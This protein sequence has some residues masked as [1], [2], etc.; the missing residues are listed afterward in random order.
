MKPA[1]SYILHQEEPFRSILLQLQVIIEQSFPHVVL[2][3]KWNIPFYEIGNQPLCYL[4]YSKKN[5]YV[6]VGFWLSNHLEKYHHFLV[7]GNRKVVKS[8]R[9]TSV[10]QI[11][12]EILVAILKESVAQKRRVFTKEKVSDVPEIVRSLVD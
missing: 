7:S 11:D 6:D 12:V 5:G 2:K 8:L 4:N 3:L 9:Y 10:N 1:E